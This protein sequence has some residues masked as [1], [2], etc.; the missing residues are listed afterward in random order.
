MAYKID[1]AHSQIQFT[2]RHMM[3]SKVRGW[4]EKFEGEIAL[5]EQHPENTTV[6]VRVETASINTR[7]SARDAHLRSADFFDAENHPY[8]TFKSK[9][10][11]LQGDNKARMIGDL[12][13]RGVTKE[14][15]VDVEHTGMAKSPWGTISHGF[16]G[17]AVINRKDWGL[18]WNAALETG[19]WLVGD[20]VTIDIELELI[21]TPEEAEKE[22]ASEAAAE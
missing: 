22:A 16:N 11:E 4:F 14:V 1:P 12:T 13:I 5:D 18:N 6:D 17:H 8:M 3:I 7:E 2:V 15:V 20:E 10:V 21:Y 19:G 9:R